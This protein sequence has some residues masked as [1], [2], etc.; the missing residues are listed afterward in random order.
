MI[1]REYTPLYEQTKK[2]ALVKIPRPFI[3][4]PIESGSSN[5]PGRLRLLERTGYQVQFRV[6]VERFAA[7]VARK[8]DEHVA[9]V[10]IRNYISAFF[11]GQ[12]M[13]TELDFIHLR[14]VD[15]PEMRRAMPAYIFDCHP[16][17]SH[18]SQPYWIVHACVP[19]T[20]WLLQ[21]RVKAIVY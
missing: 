18:R 20:Q 1:A 12:E 13:E 7:I 8:L 5:V 17:P 6:F 21:L 19:V 9:T 15:F 2:K 10:A 14:I 3:S 4:Y 11:G 16:K